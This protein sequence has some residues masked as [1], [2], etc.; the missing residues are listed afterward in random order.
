M[1]ESLVAYLQMQSINHKLHIKF[2]NK[3]RNI[4]SPRYTSNN[5]KQTK[6]PQRQKKLQNEVLYTYEKGRWS[7]WTDMGWFPRYTVN[8]KNKITK[9]YL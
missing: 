2:E 4:W 8:L 5:T 3:E 9:E 6:K 1:F 7:L